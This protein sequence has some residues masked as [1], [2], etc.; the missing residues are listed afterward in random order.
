MVLRERTGKR[1]IIQ[2]LLQEYVI[3]AAKDIQDALKDVEESS[4][5]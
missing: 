2:R 5:K 4:K 1:A 3:K